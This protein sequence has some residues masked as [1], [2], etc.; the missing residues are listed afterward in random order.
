MDGE[1]LPELNP[2]FPLIFSLQFPRLAEVWGE[3][4]LGPMVLAGA[5]VI[6]GSEDC[7]SAPMQLT[8]LLLGLWL[9]WSNKQFRACSDWRS[10]L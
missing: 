10:S 5:W 9:L 4:R 8:A 6:A 1:E 3:L 7:S 2:G